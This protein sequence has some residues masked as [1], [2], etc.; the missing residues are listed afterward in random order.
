[1][2]YLAPL[3]VFAPGAALAHDGPLGHADPHGI[4]IVAW[5]LAAAAIGWL[6][7]RPSR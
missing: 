1:M 2:K 6:V 5:A 7:L 4:E 3:F